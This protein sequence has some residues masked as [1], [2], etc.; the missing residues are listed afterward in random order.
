MHHL[1]GQPTTLIFRMPT[2][3]SPHEVKEPMRGEQGLDY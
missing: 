2:S 3:L 1:V